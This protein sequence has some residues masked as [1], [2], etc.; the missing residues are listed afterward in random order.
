MVHARHGADVDADTAAS[1][2]A[3]TLL[4]PSIVPT[5]SVG[6]PI[7]GCAGTPKSNASSLPSAAPPCRWR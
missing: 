4:P 6:L 3:F 2:T 7:T 5:F 1:G